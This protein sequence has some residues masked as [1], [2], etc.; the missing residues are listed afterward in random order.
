MPIVAIVAAAGVSG[1]G[2][3]NQKFSETM[4]Q[5]PAIGLPAGTPE[6]PAATP[7]YPAVHDIPPPR[8]SVMLSDFE[9]RKLEDDLVAARDQQQSALG[10]KPVAKKPEPAAKSGAKPA[11]KPAVVP[12]SASQPIY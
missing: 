11:A 2:S 5:M 12:V 4:S 7:D 3:I 8:N 1:C 10:V 9:Q 6:R